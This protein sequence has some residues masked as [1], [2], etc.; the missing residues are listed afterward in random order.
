V[1]LVVSVVAIAMGLSAIYL[2]AQYSTIVAGIT[3]KRVL[4][5]NGKTM[6]DKNSI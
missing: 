4:I 3:S 6:H 5:E 1:P 2:I